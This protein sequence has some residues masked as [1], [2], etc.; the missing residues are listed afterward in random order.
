MSEELPLAGVDSEAHGT[1]TLAAFHIRPVPRI[2]L[3]IVRAA[4]A[5]YL[6]GYC[7][8]DEGASVSGAP[9]HDN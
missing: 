7:Y 6:I 8:K 1:L 2:E 3:R 5:L 4:D 9:P